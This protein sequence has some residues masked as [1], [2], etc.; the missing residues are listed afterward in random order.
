[1][2]ELTTTLVALSADYQ[3]ERTYRDSA[4]PPETSE[5]ICRYCGKYR[6]IYPGSKLD[7]H[8]QCMVSQAFK[9]RLATAMQDPRLTYALLAGAIGVPMSSIRA[10]FR[11]AGEAQRIAKVLGRSPE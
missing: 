2:S 3:D 1:M 6:I 4:F 10:W 5:P 7:G 9:R 8:T 11:A